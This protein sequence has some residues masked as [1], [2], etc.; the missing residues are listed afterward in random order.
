MAFT[1]EKR[2]IAID[3]SLGKDALLLHSFAGHEA[4]SQPF[5][6][7]AD[8]LSENHSISFK[9]I[10]GK[11]VTLQVHHSEHEHRYWNGFVS[12]FAFVGGDSRFTHYHAEVVP[13]LWFLT[14]TADCRI[15]QNMTVPD[16]IL[17]IFRDLGF[18][19]VKNALE[20]SFE[21]RDYCVQYRETDFNFVS[22][23]MEQYGIF[24]FF[25]HEEDKHTLVLAN[26]PSAHK[27]CPEQPEARCNF[28]PGAL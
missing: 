11:Q 12:R 22:R 20:G 14:R 2:L 9:D 23:L 6:F 8:L 5:H 26:S 21:P 13:W 10:V 16:I 28:A 27:P 7:S 19:D 24:Y 3:T 25:E 17:K 1:Q 18:S 4:I 15:F